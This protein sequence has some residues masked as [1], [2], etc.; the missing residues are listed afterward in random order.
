MDIIELRIP[1]PAMP[2]VARINMILAKYAAFGI[3]PV[4]MP[5]PVIDG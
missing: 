2:E 4:V 1:Y 3:V 5:P